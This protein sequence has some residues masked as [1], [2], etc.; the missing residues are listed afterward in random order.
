MMTKFHDLI[1]IGGGSAG[2]AV[3]QRA[4]IIE[5]SGLGGTCV[6]NGCVP[7]KVMWYATQSMEAIRDAHGSAIRVSA[8]LLDWAQLVDRRNAYVAGS[9]PLVPAVPGAG[10]GISSDGFFALDRQPRRVAV[11]GGGYIGVELSG[12][13][14]ALGSEVSL[15]AREERVLEVFDHMIG[16]T[17]TEH[18]RAQGIALH[19]GCQ[20]TGLDRRNDGIVVSMAGA[21]TLEGFDTVI[22]A[23]GRRPNTAPLNLAAAG[24]ATGPDGAT[25]STAT[26]APVRRASM[27]SAT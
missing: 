22:W 6:N 2:L 9:R 20:V 5:Q 18:M 21:G 14:R 11:I 13:L 15:I 19:P 10:L 3:A 7:K 26:S 12:V 17:L 24:V 27:P 1:A 23:V 4:A 16:D 8:P 25:W